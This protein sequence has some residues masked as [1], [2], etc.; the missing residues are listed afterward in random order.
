MTCRNPGCMKQTDYDRVAYYA[1]KRYL[2]GVA[3][4]VLLCEARTEDDKRMIVLA[5]LLDV[6]DDKLHD[7]MPGCGPRCRCQ[8]REM[9]ARLRFM[10]HQKRNRVEA[11]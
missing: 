6:D 1:R 5:S 3:T 7:L 2:D 4:I 8:M 9:R 11:A 10:I